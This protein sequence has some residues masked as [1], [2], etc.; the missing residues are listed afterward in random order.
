ME[1]VLGIDSGGTS[2]KIKATALD[3]TALGEYIGPTCSHYQL[4]V[5]YAEM[6][7]SQNINTCLALFGGKRNDCRFI[8]AGSTG[9]DCDEDDIIISD[10]Y[11]G[12]SG[13]S[14]PIIT[15]SD[16]ELAHY[17]VIGGKGILLIVG[18]GSIVFGC[19]QKG[20][21]ARVGGWAR[22]LMGDEGSGRYI[23]AWAL[24]HVSRWFD[25]CRN[26][27]ILAPMIA[28]H[29][30]LRTRK[31]LMELSIE[32]STP[33]WVSPGLGNLVNEAAQKQVRYAISILRNAVIW[34]C[35]MIID[36][37]KLLN[38]GNDA[39]IDVGVW[40]S[41]I[42]KGKIHCSMLQEALAEYQ[43]NVR[44]V[45]PSISATDGAVRYALKGL[46]DMH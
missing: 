45:M 38:M 15:M 3:G 12:L 41:A 26:D 10:L 2:F 16:V 11:H 40:G 34:N 6:Q 46:D 14:C 42:V 23:D 17:T 35:K 18:T 43:P 33:P 30:G 8:V 20:E 36:V 27:S 13:F 31:D 32:M 37:I 19:N 24:H 25:G 28:N 5:P 4:T 22:S 39:Q 1:Y 21:K 29:L 7:I 9:H 44:F